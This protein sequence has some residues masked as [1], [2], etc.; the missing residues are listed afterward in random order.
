MRPSRLFAFIALAVLAA[1]AL[2]ALPPGATSVA[3]AAPGTLD[4]DLAP[5]GVSLVSWGGGTPQELVQAADARGCYAVSL[6]V[7][8]DGRF[9]GYSPGSPAFANEG[10]VSLFPGGAMGPGP[11]LLVCLVREEAPPSGARAIEGTSCT[12]FPDD[13]PWAQRIDDLPVHPNSDGYMAYL[14]GLSGNRFLHADFGEHPDYGIPWTVV[15][16]D[17]PRVPVTFDYDDESDP[18][19]YPI[20]ADAPVEA[21]SDA[22]VLVV[23]DGDCVLYELFAAERRGVGWHAGSGAVF[24]L[25]SNALRPD[26]WTSADAAGL[27]IFAGLARHEEVESGRIE[28][29]LRVTFSRTQRAYIHPATH[30]ASSITD[31]D[32]PPMGLRLRLRADFDLSPYSG[33]ARVLLEAMRDYGLIVADNGSN[34]Y[35]SGATDP[36]WDD[37]DLDQLKSVP[38]SAFEAVYTGEI[39]GR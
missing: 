7:T 2:P 31:A 13:N 3:Q 29:A 27:P 5:T 17:Q 35:V 9:R 12:L 21:G 33:H 6:W 19:P 39:V 8:R 18:G 37:D 11:V 32:A 30:F 16:S 20:P 14:A 1:L 15:P 36:R 24:D 22:H 10:F 4:G 25:R 28:H 23:Q 26:G 34:W 38:G